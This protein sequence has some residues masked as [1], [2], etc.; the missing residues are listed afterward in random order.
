MIQGDFQGDMVAR[1]VVVVRRASG[2]VT[3]VRGWPALLLLVVLVTAGRA[4]AQ[5]ALDRPARVNVERAPL[6]EALRLLQE[7]AAVGL[8]FS[9]DLLPRVAVSC[10]C[11]GRTVR[12]ALELM[13]D[14]TGL[15]FRVA[16][17][18]ILIVP[19]ARA[20]P[21]I[22]TVV[23]RISDA[24]MGGPVSGV[25]VRLE[26]GRSALVDRSGR[27]VLRDVPT[28]VHR[29]EVTE[30]GWE[31]WIEEL[32]VTAGDTVALDV[33]LR[34]AA[35]PLPEII[36]TPGTFGILESVPP[37]AVKTMTREEIETM[38]QVVEDVFRSLTRLPGVTS[39]DISARLSVRGSLDR[40]VT[41]RLDGL[42][43]Y[44]P[45]HLNE[46]GGVLGI[47]DLATLAG[48][49]LKAGG[50]GVED[51]PRGA[52]VLD[53]KSATAVGPAQTA[54]DLSLSHLSL[55]SKGGFDAGRGSWLVSAR[56]GLLFPRIAEH[57]SPAF[58]D[59]F[60]KVAWE[61]APGQLLTVHV[62][63]AHDDLKL[64]VEDPDG[65]TA[66]PGIEGGRMR[67]RWS[68]GYGWITWDARVGKAA[69]SSAQLWFGRVARNRVGNVEDRGT[70]GS[71][72]QIAVSDRRGFDFGGVREQVDL[73]VAPGLLLRL[74]AEVMRGT[75][76]FTYAGRTATP[77]FAPDGVVRLRT[78]TLTVALRPSGH[79]LSAY[80]A[81]RGRVGRLTAELGVRYDRLSQVDESRFA[82]RAQTSISL[83]SGTTLQASAGRYY[84]SQEIGELEVGS[85][86]T[87][88]WPSERSSLLALGLERRIDAQMSV[89]LE[90]YHRSI[91]N[92]QPRF[93]SLEQELSN[94]FAERLGDRL[95]IDPGRGRERGIELYAQWAPGPRWNVAAS[96]A[97]AK[98]E[99]EIRHEEPCS[100]RP[101]CLAAPWV[102]RARDQR[103]AVDLQVAF[104]PNEKWHLAA[105][106]VFHTGWP[107][108]AWTYAAAHTADGSLFWTKEYGPLRAERL[109]GYHRLDLRATRTFQFRRGTLEA[110]ADLINVYNRRNRD[111]YA[112]S[113]RFID[114]QAVTVPTDAE[115]LVPFLP[116][117]GL[118]L[119][120]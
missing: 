16:Q 107:A 46:W 117:L 43:L 13:L 61:P 85:G 9:T 52:A 79:R 2:V 113:G 115:N 83:G 94:Y 55:M 75:A 95:R 104:T 50:F 96:Y 65:V 63:G 30:I 32:T 111:A 57:L 40:D 49:E 119:R 114:G 118:R 105:A 101:I 81:A 106:W 69:S 116:T 45:F 92:Q 21:S 22:G 48:V 120:F 93:I 73:E 86:Q 10:P 6:E 38:P 67:S 66:G 60:G 80:A 72:E 110:F 70:V 14:G 74:G 68:S 26:T 31:P 18:R 58:Y 12:D 35:V 19:R 54:S 47:V 27:F 90:A 109:P 91:S 25:V 103:H 24:G 100:S 53:M 84:Q 4:S 41:L 15:T 87:R 64:D 102:P 33:R 29:L 11:D 97:L 39:H 23:G 28:G 56:R 88:Y 5:S 17:S 59:V 108:T 3:G 112:Y 76:D 82:P 71:P 51:G 99:D 34:L 1:S 77:T 8:I 42:E 62:L 36:V 44:E 89:R 98:A 20:R 37:G 78:D 7:R